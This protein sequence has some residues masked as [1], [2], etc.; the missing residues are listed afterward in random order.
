MPMLRWMSDNTI[1][2]GI[3]PEFFHK[4]F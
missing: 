4:K 3:E 1:H 2:D